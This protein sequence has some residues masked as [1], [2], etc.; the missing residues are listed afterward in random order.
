[1][2]SVLVDPIQTEVTPN[3]LSIGLTVTTTVEKQPEPRTYDRVAVPDG[4]VDHAYIPVREPMVATVTSLLL[5]V[6]PGVAQE[7]MIPGAK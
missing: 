7:S 6:P 4:A 1:M 2:V 3:M 5:H